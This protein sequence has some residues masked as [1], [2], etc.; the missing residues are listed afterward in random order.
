MKKS[1]SIFCV[2]AAIGMFVLSG[3]GG[4]K[5]PAS[6]DTLVN[7][8][9]VPSK[10]YV[11]DGEDGVGAENGM[12]SPLSMHGNGSDVLSPR[13][14]SLTA[15]DLNALYKPENI[16]CSIHYNF[17][18]SAVAPSERPI[19]EELAQKLRADASLR[20]LVAGHCDWHGTAEYNLALGGR[21]ANGVIHY[22]T[23]LGIE[24]GRFETLSRGDMDA[25]RGLSKEAGRKDRRSDI[26]K[27]VK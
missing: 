9:I 23:E 6:S 20:V 8:G 21:R 15:A 13:G 1:T 5:R 14:D 3:C 27:I 16:I 7:S 25:E 24:A 19:L 17:D 10:D 2:V 18:E 4:N 26:V 12:F 22:L 11:V